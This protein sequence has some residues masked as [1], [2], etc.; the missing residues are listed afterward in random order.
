MVLP[1]VRRVSRWKY[2]NFCNCVITKDPLL[3]GEGQISIISL[4]SFLQ[5]Y[6]DDP[7]FSTS[8]SNLAHVGCELSADSSELLMINCRNIIGLIRKLLLIRTI[9]KETYMSNNLAFF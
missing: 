7:G 8:S 6:E 1:N 5:K 9:S 4:F 2:V 3:P